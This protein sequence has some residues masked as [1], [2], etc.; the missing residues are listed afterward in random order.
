MV[1]ECL[2]ISVIVVIYDDATEP[3]SVGVDL[4]FKPLSKKFALF[5]LNGVSKM[6]KGAE[7]ITINIAVFQPRTPS[8]YIWTSRF[9]IIN[10]SHSLLNLD[11]Y[12][13]LPLLVYQAT[14]AD[15]VCDVPLLALGYGCPSPIDVNL[16]YMCQIY[17]YVS[18]QPAL[19]HQYTAKS[20]QCV[21]LLGHIEHA[22]P[23]G[24]P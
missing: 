1:I 7:I 9:V 8:N 22:N 4:C 17:L 24:S 10:L 5:Y 3:H 16:A 21:K 14:L 18:N 13:Y 11:W 19:N 23:W 12:G 6:Q 2:G 20:E 15:N